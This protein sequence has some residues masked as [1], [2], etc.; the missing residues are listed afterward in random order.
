MPLADPKPSA[1]E[2]PR[3]VTLTTDIGWAYAAQVK[4]VLLSR[5]LRFRIVDLT[6]T[7]V[8]HS[9]LEGAFLLRACA[10]PFPSGSVHLCIVDPGV[11]SE[12]QPIMVR[13]QDGSLLVGP[14]NG[15]L[16]PL[17]RALGTAGVFRIEPEGLPTRRPV[18]PTFEGR[19]LF[20]PTAAELALGKAPEDL[21]S[22]SQAVHFDLPAPRWGRGSSEVA[23]LHVDPFG[24]LVTNLPHQ[25]LLDRIGPVGSHVS[26]E[27]G[28]RRLR[29]K[30]VRTYSDLEEGCLGAL[31]SSFGLTELCLRGASAQG[32]LDLKV[33]AR[34][35]LLP[36][37][38]DWKEGA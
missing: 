38:R 14:D 5:D 24:N 20:A 36:S 11:G 26:V 37:D 8:S 19:D 16:M 30:V 9:I 15:V 27:A 7:V 2:R 13:C 18:S 22:P 3:L 6:H 21:G 17:A 12:R 29:A 23:L 28:A 10:L 34:L 35:R 1:R 4:G 33:G 31:G 32:I 25:E